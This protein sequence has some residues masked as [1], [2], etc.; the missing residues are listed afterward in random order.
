MVYFSPVNSPYSQKLEYNPFEHL[1]AD[2]EK[3]SQNGRLIVMGDFNARTAKPCDLVTTERCQHVLTLKCI[4][5]DEDV[6]KQQSQDVSRVFTYGK[7]LIDM[8]VKKCTSHYF[9]LQS[10]LS[11]SCDMVVASSMV[12]LLSFCG[13]SRW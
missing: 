6:A 10:V 1:T 13:S 12:L 8:C 5:D 9:S 4:H 11:L 3:Y 7:C 2:I